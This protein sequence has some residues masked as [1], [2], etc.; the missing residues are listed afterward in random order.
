MKHVTKQVFFA[1]LLLSSGIA[2]ADSCC[3]TSC[4][5]TTRSVTPKFTIR[6]QG[7][8][9]VR[10]MVQS[11]GNTNLYDIDSFNGTFALTLEYG[12]S[13][14]NDE[15]AKCLFGS[16]CKIDVQGS[17][18]V[19]RN[20]NAWLADYFYLPT[21]F[22]GSF[23]V[24]PKIQNFSADFFYYFGLDQWAQGLYAW[25]Q[26]PVTWTKWDLNFCEDIRS[27]GTN[28]HCEGYFTPNE[29][30]R[31]QLLN[32]FSSYLCGNAPGNG[33]ISQTFDNYAEDEITC[34]TKFNSLN[35]AK[36]CC[37]CGD[38][39]KTT[40]PEIRFALGWNFLLEEDYHLGLNIQASAPTGNNVSPTYLFA[41]QNGNDNHWELGVGLGTHFILWRSEDEEKHFGF[42][43]DANV[44]H[45]FNNSQCRCF[46]LCG[47]PLSRYMLAE[48]LT[49]P[50][51]YNLSG[52]P[53]LTS[54]TT[55]AANYQFAKEFAPVAN[56]TNLKVDVS[57]GVNADIV[58][59]FNYT[60]CG[61][62]WDFGYN[63]WGRS[64]EKIKL[65]CNCDSF[66]E[67]TWA[68]KGDAAVY[69]YMLDDSP[70]LIADNPVALSATMSKATIN[71]GD[72]FGKAG[73]AG[74]SV[75]ALAGKANP[76][77]D[78]PQIAL[79]G[80]TIDD[81]QFLTPQRGD[82]V[83]VENTHTSIQPVF[84]KQS[85]INFARTKG[86]SHKI[87]SHL[88]YSWVDREKW[89]PYVGVGFEAEFASHGDNCNDDCCNDCCTSS[90][91]T[92]CCDSKETN[93]NCLKC[94]LSQWGVW[95]KGGVSY[96]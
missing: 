18:L 61:L 7:T 58:A 5:S 96:R 83:N 1:L 4:D 9:A 77:I 36:I 54:S 50:V 62:S 16:S 92:V 75:A 47:K 37:D 82:I 12:Q 79:A 19:G 6:S 90:C 13:F 40:V 24:D 86:I 25:I 68:L 56:I 38:E 49:Q 21:D 71:G 57:V 73:V 67:N 20:E 76:N 43:L 28:N 60:S 32:S 95:I 42:Y 29:L 78:N 93:G 33:S 85:D 59:M 88:G 26:F 72:N 52:I 10:R 45:M 35:C 27:T 80:G 2:I 55:T 14:D 17:H 15:I 46:D 89:I 70:P 44:T 30:P 23:S 53:D 66:K 94:G 91:D 41:P 65:D 48:K 74:G 84:I 87:F 3:N 51:D 64:C 31:A 81:L 63:F 11:V 8:N 39:T 22:D 69:G 34:V